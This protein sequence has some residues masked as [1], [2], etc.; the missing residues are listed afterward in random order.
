MSLKNIY[1]LLVVKQVETFYDM[2]Y[3]CKPLL[4]P[5]SM[6]ATQKYSRAS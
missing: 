4:I 3:I 6:D 2:K 1:V 5:K